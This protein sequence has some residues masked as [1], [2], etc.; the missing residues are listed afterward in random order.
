VQQP[1]QWT[2]TRITEAR[3]RNHCCRKK[4]NTCV[5]FSVCVCSLSYP[6]CKTRAQYYI[7]ICGLSGRTAF[8]SIISWRARIS[9]QGYCT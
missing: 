4:R 6:T 9:G 7:V 5:I 8:F 2:Y 3:S 1:R